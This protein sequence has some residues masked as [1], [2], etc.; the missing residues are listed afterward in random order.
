[1]DEIG[2]ANLAEEERPEEQL[3][4]HGTDVA[5]AERTAEDAGRYWVGRDQAHGDIRVVLPAPHETLGLHRLTAE[6]AHGRGNEGDVKPV[7]SL[8]AHQHEV[9]G[10]E[11]CKPRAELL[12]S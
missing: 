6:D 12:R 5:H 9:A 1:M 10:L 3:G 7:T 8:H 4:Q 11:L 2:A